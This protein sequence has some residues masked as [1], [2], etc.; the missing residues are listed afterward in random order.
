MSDPA[1]VVKNA[2]ILRQITEKLI[3]QNAYSEVDIATAC[4]VATSMEFYQV[5]LKDISRWSE[6]ILDVQKI[7]PGYACHV[8]DKSLEIKS[9]N[10]LLTQPQADLIK[11]CSSSVEYV[12][13]LEF[14]VLF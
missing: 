5:V 6:H 7:L 2:D 9:Y 11:Q 8:R 4:T 10:V 13:K 14:H 12:R 3:N 1:V